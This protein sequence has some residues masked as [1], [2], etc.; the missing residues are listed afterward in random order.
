MAIRS[1]GGTGVLVAL[2]VFVLTTVFLLVMTIVFFSGKNAAEDR[3]N[4]AQ[5]ELDSFINR[6]QQQADEA[7][8]VRAAA[9]TERQSVYGF[10]MNQRAETAAWIAGN[11]TADLAA[12][13]NEL[14]VPRDQTVKGV[15]TDLRR[16]LRA[17]TD[18][19]ASLTNRIGDLTRQLAT[20]RDAMEAA[21][22]ECEQRVEA[23]RGEIDQYARAANDLKKQVSDARVS[24][25]RTKDDRENRHRSRIGELQTEIDELRAERSVLDSR[26]LALEAKVR[27]IELKPA[28]P[29]ELV[30]GRIIAVEGAG[31][32]VFIDIG[33]VDRVVPGMTFE[34]FED[35][36]A[37]PSSQRGKATI[38][39]LRVGEATS[40]AKVIRQTT[41]RPVVKDDVIANAV[42]NPQYRFKFLVHGKFD[43]SGDGRP[44]DAGADYVR[45]RIVEWGGEVVTGDQLTGDLD[46]LVL[47]YQPP[48]PSPLPFDATE[49]QIQANL[50]ARQARETYDR[51]FRQA[52]DARIPVLNWHRFL[53]LTGGMTGR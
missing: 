14:G 7:K 49:A 17:K 8:A 6:A 41:G 23:I 1:G 4:T 44:S 3:A 36:N 34:V 28:N 18:E 20:A 29:A 16:Q 48:M 52:S 13:Q 38:Q 53:A 31:E 9:A 40:T 11:R 10:L 26:L 37:I 5:A 50:E 42:F 24:I 30:D 22:V 46:F 2:V 43:V 32:Q 25:E 39:V 51:L 27:T 47:G 21:R 33:R 45:S 19:V 35:A 12:M 15:L